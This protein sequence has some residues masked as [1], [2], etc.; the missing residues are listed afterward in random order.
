MRRARERR[1]DVRLWRERVRREH[2]CA[3]IVPASA[4]STCERGRNV[5]ECDDSAGNAVAHDKV[6][7]VWATRQQRACDSVSRRYKN[8]GGVAPLPALAVLKVLPMEQLDG[9]GRYVRRHTLGRAPV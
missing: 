3:T 2:V 7:T 6:Q 8:A 1:V 4:T 5:K 9:S